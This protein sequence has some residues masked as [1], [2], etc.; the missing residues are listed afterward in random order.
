M[1]TVPSAIVGTFSPRATMP[2]CANPRCKAT[3]MNGNGSVGNILIT[4]PCGTPPEK[5]AWLT[6]STWS[7][8]PWSNSLR[9][10]A[11]CA[12][13]G[14]LLNAVIVTLTPGFIPTTLINSARCCGVIVLSV[15]LTSILSE[16][17]FVSTSSF[18]AFVSSICT[19][20]CSASAS[21]A[22]F[23]NYRIWADCRL[24][25]VRPLKMVSSPAANVSATNPTDATC[26]I[27][28]QLS[29]VMD[30]ILEFVVF[31]SFGLVM[32]SSIVFFV[33]MWRIRPR[34]KS[35]ESE[36]IFAP[37]TNATLRR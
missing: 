2:I 31:C 18:C 32:L 36:E 6:P 21:V 22:A 13:S 12:V 26:P 17:C 5:N 37:A 19:R 20:C 16:S 24:L 9:L 14:S 25:T 10:S 23:F 35:L 34:G 8:H 1:S 3:A 7:A 4:T 28:F 27:Q 33:A 11:N 29:A 30:R 15:V